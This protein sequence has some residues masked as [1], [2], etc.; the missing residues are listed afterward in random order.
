MDLLLVGSSTPCL[1]L[2]LLLKEMLRPMSQHQLSYC[3]S[4]SGVGITTEPFHT[5]SL[6]LQSH[7]VYSHS[8]I[9]MLFLQYLK[10]WALRLCVFGYCARIGKRR[11]K[12]KVQPVQNPTRA[13][14]SLALNR[15][16]SLQR[17]KHDTERVSGLS[18]VSF[19]GCMT[20]A[21]G[22]E[23]DR[24]LVTLILGTREQERAAVLQQGILEQRDYVW[25]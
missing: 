18:P 11:M 19:I 5:L 8:I 16:V 4:T 21:L 24:L 14:G 9:S 7:A 20:F 1:R 25:A 22:N 12:N 23:G 17:D 6:G 10:I 15:E 2:P 13:G 3:C